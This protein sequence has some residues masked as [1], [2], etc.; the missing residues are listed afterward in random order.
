VTVVERFEEQFDD[1]EGGKKRRVV[2]DE[3]KKI[4]GILKEMMITPRRV[5]HFD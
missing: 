4:K 2:K 1:G 5:E 3:E